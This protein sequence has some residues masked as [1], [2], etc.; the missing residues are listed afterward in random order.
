MAQTS[1]PF[2]SQTVSESQYSSYFREL[3]DTGVVGSSDSSSLKVTAGT[4]M[5][6]SVAAGSAI[7]R[8]HFYN[9]D[10]AVTLSIAAAD[11]AARTDRIVLRLDP[12]ANSIVLAVIKGTAGGGI[13]SLNQTDTGIYEVVLAN[14]AVGAGAASIVAANITEQRRFVSSRIGTWST[15]LRPTTPRLGRLG[16]N[17]DTS[18][19]EFWNGSAWTNL[20]QSVDWA[21]LSNKPSTFPP[22]THSHDWNSITAKPTTFPPS[23]HTTNWSDIV[24]EPSTYPP[25]THSH[26][27]SSITS[28]PSTFTP[29]SHSHSAYLESGDTIS[30][31]NGSKKPFSNSVSDGGP[32]YA[33]WVEGSGVFARNTS[34]IRFKEN[35][36]DHPIDPAKVLALRPVIYDRKL[37]EGKTNRRTDEFGLIAEEVYEQIPEVV[38]ILDGEVDGLRYDLLPVAMLSVL[39]DQQARIERLEKLVEELSK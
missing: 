37:E 19:W 10:A 33:V 5:T 26:S 6:V 35:V 2:D 30:W 15:A 39:Q 1:Y 28:K 13:P 36:R 23:A 21:S 11:T 22:D 29:S 7:V 12:A 8:G 31:A 25:S 9:S 24:G 38:N 32:Y 17:T 14:V 4:G 20:T 3:Q 18:T 27:W 34:S 16:Y